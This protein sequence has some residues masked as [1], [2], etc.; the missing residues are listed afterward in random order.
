MRVAQFIYAIAIKCQLWRPNLQPYHMRHRPLRNLQMARRG[1]TAPISTVENRNGG[2]RWPGENDPPFLQ[3]P[4]GTDRPRYRHIKIFRFV[5]KESKR[6][7]FLIIGTSAR[8]GVAT[9]ILTKVPPKPTNPLPV[10]RLGEIFSLI[11]GPRP[12]PA[13]RPR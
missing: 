9:A 3:T 2:P 1:K 6:N 12:A 7:L 5:C 10:R 11:I 13:C 8:P 4:N